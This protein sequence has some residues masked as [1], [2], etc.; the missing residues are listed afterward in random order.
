MSEFPLN[1]IGRHPVTGENIYIR[2]LA[3][4]HH[5]RVGSDFR[6]G[7]GRLLYRKLDVKG[8]TPE[9]A[10]S[11]L[12][13]PRYV[14][15]H[16]IT[17]GQIETDIRSSGAYISYRLDSENA[18]YRFLSTIDDVL[19]ISLERAVEML[20]E[21]DIIPESTQLNTIYSSDSTPLSQE[22]YSSEFTYLDMVKDQFHSLKNIGEWKQ[23][24]SSVNNWYGERES[25][26]QIAISSYLTL[27]G[28]KNEMEVRHG[29][30]RI[31]IHIIDRKTVVEVKKI[32]DRQSFRTGVTQL[33]TYA[34][35]MNV[36]HKI[37]VGLPCEE[38]RERKQIEEWIK[39]HNDWELKV[40]LLDLGM[41]DL[42]LDR[43]F[44]IGQENPMALVSKISRF[45][46]KVFEIISVYLKTNAETT[47]KLFQT[48][49]EVQFNFNPST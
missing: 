20:S 27:Q 22:T 14:G 42:D 46:E 48:S 23:K 4:G 5:L 35:R 40:H 39:I 32:I 26:I 3:H 25:F 33:T 28:V 43:I 13:L 41:E 24:I 34:K 6:S 49:P 21:P 45:A 16:P 30:S 44:Q 29:D 31:D 10:L 15:T 38:M 18:V 9:I 37:L 7:K 12:S 36:T 2:S 8:M 19:N 17:G 47:K 11:L 1:N